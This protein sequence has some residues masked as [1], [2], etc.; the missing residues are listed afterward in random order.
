LKQLYSLTTIEEEKKLL[1]ACKVDSRKHLRPILIAAVDTAMRRGELLKLRWRNVDFDDRSIEIEAFNTKTARARAVAM[2]SRLESELK[3]L[4][5]NAPKDPEGLSSESKTISK[6]DLPQIV[7]FNVLSYSHRS[8][9][10]GSTLAARRAG[11]QQAIAAARETTAIET[12]RVAEWL[13]SRPAT[14]P[15]SI[16]TTTKVNPIPIARPRKTALKPCRK[17]NRCTLLGLAPKAMR[18]PISEMRRDVA[19]E[20][21]P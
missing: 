10:I 6:M 16:R 19:W 21:T 18:T 8:A 14:A 13:V 17:I 11:I 1:A 12:A 9:A 20:T 7:H 5:E 4:Y 3:Q 15:L 2:T